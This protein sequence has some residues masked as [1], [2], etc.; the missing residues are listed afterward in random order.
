M[1][2]RFK[3]DTKDPVVN[4]TTWCL[5]VVTI[6]SV[7]SRLGTKFRLFHKLSADDFFIVAS[8]VR[9]PKSDPLLALIL[10]R[11]LAYETGI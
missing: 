11:Q 2:T 9:L 7:S 5:L 3:G 10:V 1:G 4:A 6:F 8:L